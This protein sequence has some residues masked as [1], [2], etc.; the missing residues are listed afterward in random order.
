MLLAVE[1]KTANTEYILMIR[2]VFL[3]SPVRSDKNG[4][5]LWKETRADNLGKEFD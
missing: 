1:E 5:G 2:K 4:A 3:L